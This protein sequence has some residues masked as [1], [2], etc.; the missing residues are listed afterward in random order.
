MDNLAG[1]VQQLRR[2]G[3]SVRNDWSAWMLVSP[4]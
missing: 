2:E 4:L 3:I 1:V